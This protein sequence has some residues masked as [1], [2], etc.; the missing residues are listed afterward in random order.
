MS[1][2]KSEEARRAGAILK[3]MRAHEEEMAR[4]VAEL[5]AIPSE[6]PPGK[7]YRA[8]TTILEKY[9]RKFGFDF[10]RLQPRTKAKNLQ[11][12]PACLLGEYGRGERTLY[13]HGHYDVVP[14]QSRE[15]FKPIVRNGC[16]DGRGSTDM[17]S[18]LAAMIYAT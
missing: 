14:A 5:V 1:V 10:E 16:L 12:S 18:G 4:V 11:E 17:K 15:Q 6:N 7:N 2:K 3:W 13:F 8:A 9:I